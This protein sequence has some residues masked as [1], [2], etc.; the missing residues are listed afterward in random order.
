MNGILAHHGTGGGDL[1]NAS[2]KGDD[3]HVT[4][5]LSLRYADALME[6]LGPSETPA[7]GPAEML[8]DNDEK[9]RVNDI[10]DAADQ[11]VRDLIAKR[12]AERG[13]NAPKEP[14][15]MPSFP[16]ELHAP[17]QFDDVVLER[18]VLREKMKILRRIVASWTVGASTDKHQ[19]AM[20]LVRLVVN[21]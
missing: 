4:A 11:K 18:A 14:S 12:D 2:H 6:A 21:E 5:A 19:Q 8:N 13:P 17:F 7:P 1:V 3:F 20:S 10:L 16:K 9:E 15:V